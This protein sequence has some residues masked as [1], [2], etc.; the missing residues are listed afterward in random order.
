MS[1]P[2]P[3]RFVIA[4]V[5]AIGYGQRLCPPM[6]ALESVLTYLDLAPDFSTMMAVSGGAWRRF[7]ERDD[8]GNVALDYLGPSIYER[9]C[10]A[11]GCECAVTTTEDREA[12]L[13]A[14]QGS[15]MRGNPVVAS[16]GGPEGGLVTGWDK[17]GDVLIGWSYFQ[18]TG[19]AY[20]ECPNWRTS[21][22]GSPHVVIIG[23]PCE[24]ADPREVLRSSLELAIDLARTPRR[25]CA[26]A[27]VSGLAA[28]DAWADGLL[29]DE[30]YPAD[31]REVLDTRAMVYGDQVCMVHDRA[32][33]AQFLA[34]SVPLAPAAE[35]P[36]KAAAL[37]YARVPATPDLYPWQAM[38]HSELVRRSLADREVREHLAKQIRLARDTEAQAA[39]QLELALSCM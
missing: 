16:I 32:Y 36:L 11:V 20:Y 12:M 18:E 2:I 22:E 8:G 9:A 4:G 3:P 38:P 25:D 37:L 21:L 31:D 5:P 7:Y 15:L 17:G 23:D 39:E 34:D 27:H 14:I 6:G 30:D 24:P 29:I 35:E 33:G 28:Y 19:D 1:S 13:A 10:W 26:P